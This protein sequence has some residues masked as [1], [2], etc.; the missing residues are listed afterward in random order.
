M[1]LAFSSILSQ[2]FKLHRC[3]TVSYDLSFIIGLPFSIISVYR[4]CLCSNFPLFF[5]GEGVLGGYLEV[6]GVLGIKIVTLRNFVY[7]LLLRFFLS[8]F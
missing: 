4:V 6:G 2:S 1:I 8:S 7:F 5:S 3:F